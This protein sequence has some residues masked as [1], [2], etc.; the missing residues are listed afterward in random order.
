MMRMRALLLLV[1]A[2]GTFVSYIAYNVHKAMPLFDKASAITETS[3]FLLEPQVFES[4]YASL[5]KP[6]ALNKLKIL[7]TTKNAAR[8]VFQ[9]CLYD[10][11]FALYITKLSLQNTQS[12]Q[13]ILNVGRKQNIQP[14]N[15]VA[16]SQEDGRNLYLSL[17]EVG[18]SK[19]VSRIFLS[20]EQS[21]ETEMLLEGNVYSPDL[22]GYNLPL[23]GL[24]LQYNDVD[25]PVD[26][27]FSA[28]KAYSAHQGLVDLL[29][30][31]KGKDVYFLLMYPRKKDA[32]LP[33]GF[34]RQLVAL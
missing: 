20:V 18:Q 28:Y 31:R 2:I 3:S 7:S 23:R 19:Y 32:E 21:R 12:L 11:K 16:Y 1:V 27:Y 4:E 5:F 34:L 26:I 9:S 25:A 10:D 14:S 30:Y 29:F 8:N 15:D 6:E 17:S 22:I 33:R 13:N 24:T